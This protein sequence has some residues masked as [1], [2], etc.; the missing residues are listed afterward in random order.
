MEKIDFVVTWVD[1]SDEAWLNEKNKY[2]ASKNQDSSKTRYRDYEIIKYFF[3]SIE[4]Y[5]PWVNKIYFITWGHVPKWLN[6]ENPKLVIVNHKD[7]IPEEYLPTFNS[8]AIELNLHRIPSLSEYFVYFNDD[9]I[10]NDYTKAEDFFK[11]GLP[12][13]CAVLNA[14]IPYGKS[15]F[16]HR[17]VNNTNLINRN[18]DMMKVI[19][20]NLLK[21]FNVKYGK[22]LIRTFCLLPWKKFSSIKSYHLAISL[23][24]STYEKVWEKEENV[25]NIS[26]IDKFRSFF[27]V[28]PWVIKDW[29]ICEGKF[30]PRTYKF[31][32]LFSISEDNTELYRELKRRKYKM[33]CINDADDIKDFDETKEKLI[34]ELENKFPEKSS[35]EK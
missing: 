34:I 33:L 4:K 10:L 9:I 31:G 27:G 26:C 14:I 7:Y 6:I 17:L 16:E 23:L 20:E 1:G 21:W 30:I 32:K 13:E 28:N 15:N 22:D 3:R 24:K 2:K 25:M 18:F 35:F 12:R 5:A 8:C 29:Q 19:K 11:N